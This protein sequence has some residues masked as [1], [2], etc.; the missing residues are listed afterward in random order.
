MQLYKKLDDGT[1]EEVKPAKVFET[2]DQ[3]NEFIQEKTDQIKRN[4]FGD[5]DELK[6]KLTE[7][8]KSVE[9]LTGD[10][11][12]LEEQLKSKDGE[13]SKE[14]LNAA[15][16]GIRHEFGLSEDLDKF[17]IGEN[18]D[19]I[20]ANAE[21]LKKNGGTGGVTIKKKSDNEDP[22]E[23]PSSALAR[24]VFGASDE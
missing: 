23:S 4:Q 8:N 22:K 6:S 24:G 21:V 20:R 11:K 7:A 2:Q 15:R 5:Y 14:K 3:M 12:T 16:I 17:L 10:K 19:E 1:F 13:I 9:T 18:E